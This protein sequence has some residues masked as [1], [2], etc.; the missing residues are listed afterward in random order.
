MN[1]LKETMPDESNVLASIYQHMPI[2]SRRLTIGR[3]LINVSLT[4]DEI[5]AREP[6]ITIY[7]RLSALRAERGMSRQQLANALDISY[8]TVISLERGEYNPSL[9][10]A[11]RISQLFAL[12]VEDIFSYI[13]SHACKECTCKGGVRMG[14]L[15]EPCLESR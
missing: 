1:S 6:E 10:L 4:T 2:W 11:L 14:F 13:G 8:Q 9:E 5:Q 7:N 12:P 15:I 3:L